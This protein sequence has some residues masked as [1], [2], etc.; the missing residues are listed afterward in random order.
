[1]IRA[2]L[3]SIRYLQDHQAEATAFVAQYFE[4]EPDLAVG[5]TQKITRALAYDGRMPVEASDAAGEDLK[6]A[7]SLQTTARG[8]EFVDYRLLDEVSREPR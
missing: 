4:I 8:S 1:M 5:S 6:R 2:T 7:Q 3:A